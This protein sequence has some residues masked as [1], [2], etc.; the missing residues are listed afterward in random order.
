LVRSYIFNVF[1][2]WLCGSEHTL[3][4]SH[5]FL[6]YCSSQ[7]G[8]AH[9]LWPCSYG[10]GNGFTNILTGLPSKAVKNFEDIRNTQWLMSTPSENF[11]YMDGSQLM[12]QF[13]ND[14]WDSMLFMLCTLKSGL[15]FCLLFT[16]ELIFIIHTTF[17]HISHN[18]INNW[19]SSIPKCIFQYSDTNYHI[20]LLVANDINISVG[21]TS[22]KKTGLLFGYHDYYENTHSY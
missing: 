11:M 7:N 1:F 6:F 17:S 13:K 16:K 19:F 20:L 21:T 5:I 18:T 4:T 10:V 15:P 14:N 2:L 8:L 9:V 12:P 22:C 3:S